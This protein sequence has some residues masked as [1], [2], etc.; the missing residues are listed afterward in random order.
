ME[1]KCDQDHRGHDLAVN[2]KAKGTTVHSPSGLERKSISVN[3][4]HRRHCR[5]TEETKTRTSH[6]LWWRQRTSTAARQANAQGPFTNPSPL[7]LSP[8]P[9]PLVQASGGKQVEV[10]KWRQVVSTPIRTRESLLIGEGI[11][12]LNDRA[13]CECTSIS[14]SV[15]V[16]AIRIRLALAVAGESDLR[17]A[18]TRPDAIWR[19]QSPYRDLERQRGH[20]E[21]TWHGSSR[22]ADE[23]NCL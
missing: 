11:A 16:V 18:Y 10:S 23:R 5:V 6:A 2:R 12:S 15:C 8:A 20:A 4:A 22:F 17:G 13:E 19:E 9:A 21:I 14:R 3:V 7:S 1:S